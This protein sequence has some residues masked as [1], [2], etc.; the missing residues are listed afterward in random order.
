MYLVILQYP[1]DDFPIRLFFY[2]EDAVEF[3][4]SLD[5]EFWS[6]RA[7]NMLCT[8]MPGLPCSFVSVVNFER[9]PSGDDYYTF[10][11]RKVIREL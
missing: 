4:K 9:E 5:I 1:I 2:E 3:A 6:N 10:C 8:E 7:A 11:G